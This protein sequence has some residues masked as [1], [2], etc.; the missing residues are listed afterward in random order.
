[1]FKTAG[2][3]V[4]KT[5][6][7]MKQIYEAER[8]KE[9]AAHTCANFPNLD[10][11][12]KISYTSGSMNVFNWFEDWS[13]REARTNTRNQNNGGGAFGERVAATADRRQGFR[14]RYPAVF[15]EQRQPW[16][17]RASERRVAGRLHGERRRLV[18]IYNAVAE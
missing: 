2:A 18:Y 7:Q 15:S 13:G 6:D 16:G 11:S 4:G 5:F 8:D 1:V 9:F 3:L 12:A 17:V 10:L 14:G